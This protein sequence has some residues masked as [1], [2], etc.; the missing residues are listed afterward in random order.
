VQ[1]PALRERFYPETFVMLEFLTRSDW[2]L[3]DSSGA[4]MK[5]RLPRTVKRRE[6]RTSNI[7]DATLYLF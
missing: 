2:T 7:D 6:R 4:Q 1:A 3:A 5:L